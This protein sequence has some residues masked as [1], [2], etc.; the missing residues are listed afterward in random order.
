MSKRSKNATTARETLKI[1]EQGFYINQRNQQ[2]KLAQIQHQAVAGSVH[3]RPEMFADVFAKRNTILA[4]GKTPVV[5]EVANAT[6][7]SAARRLKA[8]GSAKVLAL[9]FASAKNP[10]GGFLSGS[11]AQEESLARASGLYATQQAQFAFYEH[12]RSGHSCLYSDHVIYSPSV[13]VFRDDAG[14]LLAQPWQCHFLTAAAVNAGA[15]RQNEPQRKNQIIP[16][17]EQRTRMVLAGA[18]A[19]G[20]DALVLGA[21]GCGVFKNDP[22]V[23]AGIFAK[24]LAESPSEGQFRHIDFAVYDPSGTGATLAAFQSQFASA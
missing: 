19:H 3:Y 15:V 5:T 10:G 8:E 6:T 9:N 17:M 11:Q 13:P 14:T 24:I 22:F 20:C 7:L 23:V 18:I 4:A 21:W 12:H 1:L 16:I 2:V